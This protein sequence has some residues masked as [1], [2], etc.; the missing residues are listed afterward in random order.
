MKIGR[1]VHVLEDKE[2]KE[3]LIESD[4][5]RK[6]IISFYY[7]IDKTWKE[8]SQAFYMDLYSPRED[9]FI[10]RFKEMV[11][12]ESDSEKEHFLKNIKTNIYNNAPMRKNQVAYPVILHSAGLRCSGDYMTFNIE[13]LVNNG[14]VVFTIEHI[15]DSSFTILPNGDVLEPHKGAVTQEEKEN[16]IEVRK[17]D[18]IFVLNQLEKLNTD[19]DIIKGKL[20]LQRVGIIGHSLGGAAVF[21]ATECDPRIKTTVLL[22]ASLQFLNLS[23]KTQEKKTLNTP[24]LNFRRGK[25]D[26]ES[27][28][29][30]FI[31]YLKDKSDGDDFKK[32]ILL[33]DN[34]LRDSDMEQKRL[35]SYLGGYKSFIK[36]DGSKHMI[37]T[38][39]SIIKG[40]KSATETLS[41]KKA[42]EII[43]SV[44]IKF[45]DEFLCGKEGAYSYNIH[46]NDS[47]TLIDENGNPQN[48]S[49]I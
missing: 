19:D 47:I 5:N 24:V 31:D 48:I 14:Y 18:I 22:D 28:M 3:T 1:I 26:Y 20:D 45:L 6:V 40:E 37:F 13:S 36:L 41:V 21:K 43:N 32:E 30:M 17:N 10:S 2:R 4:E 12:L 29:K 39:H 34:I 49:R 46:N 38:D 25:F 42:H 7:P 44:T 35:F 23:K 27:S 8:S 9:E 15:Y 33:Y 11:P 16:L